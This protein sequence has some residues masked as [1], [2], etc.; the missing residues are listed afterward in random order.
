MKYLAYKTHTQLF[1]KVLMGKFDTD[2]HF[3]HVSSNSY[4]MLIS[5]CNENVVVKQK[6]TDKNRRILALGA[7]NYN[8]MLKNVYNANTKKSTN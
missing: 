5:I 3:T 2:T 1:R 6:S 8:F 4:R 7:R